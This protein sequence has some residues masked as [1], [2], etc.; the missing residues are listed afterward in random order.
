MLR[1]LSTTQVPLKSG[2]AAMT[3]K[4]R[5]RISAATLLIIKFRLDASSFFM[6]TLFSTKSCPLPAIFYH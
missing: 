4:L 1:L 6:V 5:L 2:D 3:L